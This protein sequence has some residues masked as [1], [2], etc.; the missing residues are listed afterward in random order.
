MGD[1]IHSDGI[2]TA[3]DIL[4][5]II[6]DI[7][8]ADGISRVYVCD[9]RNEVRFLVGAARDEKLMVHTWEL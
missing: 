4:R 7:I 5:L 9:S 1:S 8:G 2:S 3:R 6:V